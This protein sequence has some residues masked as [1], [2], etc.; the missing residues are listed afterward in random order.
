M[1]LSSIRVE[2]SNIVRR[3][4]EDD[5]AWSAVG[6]LVGMARDGA[7]GDLRKSIAGVQASIGA[8]QGSRAFRT[9]TDLIGSDSI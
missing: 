5:E 2:R 7:E 1:K 9:K 8:D 6:A 4:S 3:V